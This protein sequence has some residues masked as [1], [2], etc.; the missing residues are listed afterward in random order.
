MKFHMINVWCAGYCIMSFTVKTEHSENNGAP[1]MLSY[2]TILG[3]GT[4]V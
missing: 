4:K 3:K 2:M 1:K